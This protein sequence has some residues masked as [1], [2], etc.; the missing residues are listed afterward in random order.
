MNYNYQL[1]WSKQQLLPGWLP[2]GIIVNQHAFIML[3]VHQKHV[4]SVAGIGLLRPQKS[5]KTSTEP[6]Q[7]VA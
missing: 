1:N 2:V 6:N 5:V 3:L 4:Y 7:S